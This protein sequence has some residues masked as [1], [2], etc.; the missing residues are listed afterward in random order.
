MKVIGA[1][2]NYVKVSKVINEI[3]QIFEDYEGS[4]IFHTNPL[5]NSKR[6]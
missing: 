2:R 1:F 3:W 6:R 5:G 4:K